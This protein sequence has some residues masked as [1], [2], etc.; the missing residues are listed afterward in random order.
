M[1]LRI[2][3]AVVNRALVGLPICRNKEWFQATMGYAADAFTISGSLRPRSRLIRPLVYFFLHA[4]RSLNRHMATARRLLVPV[5]QHRE[6]GDKSHADVLQWMVDNAQG[7][8]KDP[9]ELTHKILFSCLASVTSSNMGIV[10]LLYDLCAMP[11]LFDPLRQEIQDVLE[12]EG[13]WTVSAIHRMKRLDSFLK[14]SQRMNHPGLC[15]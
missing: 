4:R 11:E 15:K 2:T 7:S 9:K 3:S 5:I 12:E 1:I 10:H 6:S 13:G 14:E 8:D